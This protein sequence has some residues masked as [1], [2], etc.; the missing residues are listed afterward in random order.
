MNIKLNRFLWL[1][2][3]VALLQS[4]ALYAMVE[5]HASVLRNG[6][7]I[8]L[9]AQPFDPHDLL[10]GDYVYLS[11]GISSIDAN[12]ISGTRPAANE[13]ADI[14]VTLKQ[15][16]DGAWVFS[17]AAWQRREDL[18]PGEIQL[19]GRTARFTTATQVVRVDYGIERFY[20]PEGQGQ[21]IENQQRERKIEVVIAVLPTGDAQ[22]RTLKNDGK[23]LYEEPIY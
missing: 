7:D 17:G 2:A 3:A 11:Y 19:R 15:G 5:Q 9:V 22:I 6:T 14:H 20:V 8:T 10:R 12:K 13:P 18:Q 1:G 21:A 16:D 4:G 23:V